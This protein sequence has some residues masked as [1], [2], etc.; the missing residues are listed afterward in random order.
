[1]A[2]V[3]WIAVIAGTASTG[4]NW[5]NGTGLATADTALFDGVVGT[6]NCT[7]DVTTNLNALT[8]SSGY[9]GT[10][11]QTSALNVTNAGT[12]IMTFNSA[13]TWDSSGQAVNAGAVDAS[14]SATKTLTMG[15][16]TWTIAGNFNLSGASLTLNAN[17]SQ[18][19]ITATGTLNIGSQSL[20]KLTFNG[21]ITTTITGTVKTLG[22][23]DL[24][25]AIANSTMNGGTL[26]CQG[27]VQDS[28]GAGSVTGTTALLLSGSSNQNFD[29]LGG[30]G[31]DSWYLG[32][33]TT[34]NKSG[35]TVT[36]FGQSGV[37]KLGANWTVTAGTVDAVGQSSQLRWVAAGSYTF[38]DPTNQYYQITTL[39]GITLTLNSA[40]KTSNTI[41]NAGTLVSSGRTITANGNFTNTGTFTTDGTS[42]IVFNGTS[43]LSGSTTF[44]N[45]TINSGKTV[46][47]TSTQTFTVS[48]AFTTS[49]TSTLDATTGAS[50]ANLAVNGSQSVTGVT[51][52]DIDSS[53]G[54]VKPIHNTS[55]TNSNTV[56]W[57]TGSAAANTSSMFLVF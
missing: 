54:S 27:N 7:W 38:N 10:V 13:G 45:F 55:G 37:T 50:R 23:T 5:N 4:A 18:V 9:T 16:S 15:A 3:T 35:G 21:S 19:T 40:L 44:N 46:H 57:D 42:A 53:G 11:T 48:G 32:L 36:L 49:G 51:A 30:T 29:I 26:E 33:N 47:L 56:Q 20:N 41:S 2:T 52:T 1:M 8:L 24:Q 12:K 14:G 43:T 31:S 39:S 6:A 22:L 25:S 28:A 17:T 34:I